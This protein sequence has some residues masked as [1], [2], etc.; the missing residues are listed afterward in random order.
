MKKK[1][2]IETIKCDFCEN[3]ENDLHTDFSKCCICGKDFCPDCGDIY[4]DKSKSYGL[5]IC[6]ECSEKLIMADKKLNLEG[7]NY[8][9]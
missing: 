5:S 9:I 7:E 1:I 4:F 2:Q 6:E 3:T 8:D